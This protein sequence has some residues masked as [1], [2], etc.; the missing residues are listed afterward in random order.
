MPEGWG[1]DDEGEVDMEV[2]FMPG[3]S[4]S[5]GGEETTL[6]AYQRKMREKKKKRKEEVKG[7]EKEKGKGK[8]KKL[9][10]DFFAEDSDAEESA[11][12]EAKPT[13]GKKGKKGKAHSPAPAAR[14]T[15]TAEELALVAISDNPNAEP[16][17]FDMKAVLKAEKTKGKKRRGKK[18]AK[19][20]EAE[21][22][23]DFA[24]DVKDE[25][26]K[27]LHEDHTFAIDPSNP[28]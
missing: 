26:F 14:V 24:I 4:E 27:A 19:D 20:E 18:G 12:E 28:Q 5:K 1:Q 10:D 25:R 16:K 8:E 2:T 6:E 11:E 3:L 9:D 23:E 15:S 21:L 13:K 17:H 7:K 22:Q